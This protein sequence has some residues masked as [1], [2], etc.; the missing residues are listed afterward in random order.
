MP[1]TCDGA[2]LL[3]WWPYMSR[4]DISMTAIM[5]VQRID[6]YRFDCIFASSHGTLRACQRPRTLLHGPDPDHALSGAQKVIL[7]EAAR[8]WLC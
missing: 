8:V 5:D 1:D 4:G 6:T 2:L 3:I 7:G